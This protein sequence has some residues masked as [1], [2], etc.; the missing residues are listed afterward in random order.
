MDKM[1]EIRSKSHELMAIN[2]VP[3]HPNLPLLNDSLLYSSRRSVAV[4]ERITFLFFLVGLPNGVK[5]DKSVNW[6]QKHQM[7]DGLCES[8]KNI[9][10]RALTK[11]NLS[12]SILADLSW[13]RE[14][15][16]VLFW[17]CRML[18]T[19]NWPKMKAPSI[20]TALLK[21]PPYTSYQSFMHKIKLRS[22]L[23]IVEALDLYYNLHAS[24]RHLDI[25]EDG[26]SN[27]ETHVLEERRRA[28]EWLCNDTLIWDDISLDT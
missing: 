8:E 14:A 15:S 20:E 17:A 26:K 23:E 7:F 25:W 5:A 24:H 28:L 11:K 4:T 9:F 16:Y 13:Q 2:N 6:L 27:L 1:Q 12:S 21:S 10:A 3:I 22:N 18:K 19:I